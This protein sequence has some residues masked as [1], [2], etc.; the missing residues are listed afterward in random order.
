MIFDNFDIDI[1]VNCNKLTILPNKRIIGS[2]REWHG[3]AYFIDGE[4]VYSYT[5]KEM[6][7]EPK[8]FLYLPK[9]KPYKIERP[10]KSHCIIVD[11]LVK[12]DSIA[13]PAFTRVYDFNE[14]HDVFVRLCKVFTS[15]KCNYISESK[16]F[17]YKILSLIQH[18][19][20][21]DYMPSSHYKKIEPAITHIQK[22]Y[23]TGEINMDTLADL[24]GISKR[25]LSSQ[26]VKYFKLSPKQYIIQLQL[27]L[28]RELLLNSELSI[29]KIAINCGFKNEYYFS[30]LFKKKIGESPS[31]YRKS[32]LF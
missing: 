3:F 20:K 8:S 12:N 21:T 15:K 16:S 26:F 24:S 23:T 4:A 19:E 29:S 18:Y 14:L 30:K 7:V 5:N 31:T 10:V 1:I 27:S 6:H 2:P 9:G 17:F 32:H 13:P 11:F 25:Y 22:H 28:A